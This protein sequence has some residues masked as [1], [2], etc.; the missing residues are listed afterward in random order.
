MPA[1]IPR[2]PPGTSARRPASGARAT[3]SSPAVCVM[4]LLTYRVVRLRNKTAVFASRP[5]SARKRRSPGP[6][7]EA[8]RI[9]YRIVRLPY[10]E[11]GVPARRFEDGR[12]RQA[13]RVRRG[14][15]P[16][17]RDAAVLG[18]RLRWH[19]DERAD[20]GARYQPAERLRRVR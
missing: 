1:P 6:A 13:T 14:R 3:S 17:R 16:R 18:T 5:A 19:V 10:V 7:A 20:R 8:W 12:A 11:F 15:S 2:E 4:T 9:R